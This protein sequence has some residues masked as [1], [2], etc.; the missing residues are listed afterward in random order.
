MGQFHIDMYVYI[1]CIQMLQGRNNFVCCMFS[2]LILKEFDNK[3]N[4]F[5]NQIVKNPNIEKLQT[6]IFLDQCVCL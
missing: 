5:T 2:G 4:S 6:N 3:V 1:C